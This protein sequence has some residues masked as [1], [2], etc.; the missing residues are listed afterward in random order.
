M[1]YIFKKKLIINAENN[2]LLKLE[3][4]KLIILNNF[5]KRTTIF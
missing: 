2:L 1:A 4:E 5:F 3:L